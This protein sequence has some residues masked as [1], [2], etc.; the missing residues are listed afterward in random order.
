MEVQ[1]LYLIELRVKVKESDHVTEFDFSCSFLDFVRTKDC[2][3]WKFFR[4]IRRSLKGIVVRTGFNT[5]RGSMVRSILFPKPINIK[6]ER[7]GVKFIGMMAIVGVVGFTFSIVISIYECL[8]IPATILK[9]L[10]LGKKVTI[11]SIP[12]GGYNDQELIFRNQTF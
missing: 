7:D 11:Q 6:Y 1:K 12:R 10:D 3:S 4:R 5:A 8:T 2:P 9:S